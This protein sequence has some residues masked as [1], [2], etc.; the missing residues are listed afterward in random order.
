MVRRFFPSKLPH[1][2]GG[3]GP[4]L[5]HDFLD[6]SESTTQKR[7]LDWFSRFRRD[8]DRDIQTDRPTDY[9]NRP[10]LLTYTA[11]LRCGVMRLRFSMF[12]DTA[13]VTNVRVIIII[14]NSEL[15]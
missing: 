6:P 14:N 2:N 7:H 15:T 10:H 4:R 3:S 1:S 11:V 8:H 5:T 12:A 9:N 13:R